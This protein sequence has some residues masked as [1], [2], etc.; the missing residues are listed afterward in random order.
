MLNSLV[1]LEQR[2]LKFTLNNFKRSICNYYSDEIYLLFLQAG[3]IEKVVNKTAL[4]QFCV[5]RGTA[6]KFKILLN[7]LQLKVISSELFFEIVDRAAFEH[8]D[9]P[10]SEEASEWNI[11]VQQAIYS[12]NDLNYFKSKRLKLDNNFIYEE[13]CALRLAVWMKDKLLVHLLIK[14]GAFVNIRFQNDHL[15]K[16]GNLMHL[17][18]SNKITTES[19]LEIAQLLISSGIELNTKNHDGHTPL[20]LSAI[21][22]LIH[23]ASLLIKNG[24]FINQTVGNNEDNTILTTSIRHKNYKFAHFLL[25]QKVDITFQ[26]SNGWNAAKLA[27][28]N[29]NRELGE[30][31]IQH[32]AELRPYVGLSGSPHKQ[33]GILIKVLDN[34]ASGS[35]F[36]AGIKIND[37][38][39]AIEESMVNTLSELIEIIRKFRPLDCIR[40]LVIRDSKEL[41]FLVEIQAI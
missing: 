11:L 35:A 1:E 23:L 37:I 13:S 7:C 14:R 28:I 10:D 19:D 6:F 39:I 30:R 25:D 4:A 18:A 15:A 27:F 31:L 20:S 40:F 41:N 3:I 12:C 2:G 29:R 32:G 33:G 8:F 24:A 26:N 22:N 9:V 17:I 5:K 36:A 38:L 21:N 34:T 16:T